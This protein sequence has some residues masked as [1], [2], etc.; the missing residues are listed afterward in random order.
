VTTRGLARQR[1]IDPIESFV[2]EHGRATP[3]WAVICTYECDLARLDRQVLPVL[4]RRGR[5][6]RTV[7]L[8]DAGAMEARL[9]IA[10]PPRGQVN[11][12]AVRLPK[13]GVFHPKLVLLRAGSAA[14]VCFGSANVSDGG[15]GSNLELWTYSDQGEVVAAASHFLTQLVAHPHIGVDAACRRQVQ[16]SLLGIEAAASDDVWS[17]LMETFADRISSQ[18]DALHGELTVVSPAYATD[19]GLRLARQVFPQKHAKV[20]TDQPVAV[21]A[22]SSFLYAPASPAAV[23][24]SDPPEYPNRL[25]AKLYLLRDARMSVAWMGSA[26]FT[27]QALTKTVSSGGNVECLFR[28]ELPA[29]ETKTLLEELGAVFSMVE[30]TKPSLVERVDFPRAKSSVIGGEL[31]VGP[32]GL[33]LVLHAV[34]GTTA[35]VI[36]HDKRRA[37]IAIKEGRGVLE[38]EALHRAFPRL[39][40]NGPSVVLVYEV[41][42]GN[43]IPV[44]I[45]IPFVQDAGDAASGEASLDE[46]LDELR[47]RIAPIMR[48]SED[49]GEEMEAG[50][51]AEED[52]DPALI[53]AE[54]C[55]DEAKHQGELDRIAIKAALLRRLIASTTAPGHLRDEL[56]A[57]ALTLSLAACP[58]VVRPVLA[59]W[60]KR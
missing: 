17:S 19:S 26:N 36:E 1:W 11:I 54:R 37:K 47:G 53:E 30:K 10:K 40:A 3:R 18:G 27:A 9:A 21:P 38:G 42:G 16:R 52:D 4:A 34:E 31:T 39:S 57:Q 60:F 13:G 41:V 50:E 51:P 59:R 25:H 45:N 24:E 58:A 7:V 2:R 6:F 44:L 20:F 28:S 33:R 56:L 14:R 22:A 48:A 5:A 23:E 12:H 46:L 43:R 55:L 32:R 29:D 8:A 35:V 15:M 49:D